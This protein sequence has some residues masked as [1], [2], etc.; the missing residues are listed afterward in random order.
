LGGFGRLSR[1]AP[2]IPS[3][4]PSAAHPDTVTTSS[5]ALARALAFIALAAG[6]I[7][8]LVVIS[9]S[10]EDADGPTRQGGA[11]QTR[12]QADRQQGDGR[13]GGRAA[14]VVQTGDT[15]SAIAEKTGVSIA[16]LQELNPGMDPQILTPG[17]RLRL[18]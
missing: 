10:L 2:S 8:L 15:L 16:Q 18:R 11:A 14:Y 6:V 1:A 13:R 5:K 12:T 17:D 3:R 9:T 7:A 4:G